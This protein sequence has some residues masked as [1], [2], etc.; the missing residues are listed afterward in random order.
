MDDSH[1][2]NHTYLLWK[3]FLLPVEH[4]TIDSFAVKLGTGSTLVAV[5]TLMFNLI[6]TQL[7]ALTVFAGVLYSEKKNHWGSRDSETDSTSTSILDF[8]DSAL[9]LLKLMIEHIWRSTL[10]RQ[11]S[12]LWA[13]TAAAFLVLQCALPIFI[14]RH[15]I[16]AHAAP[17]APEAIYIPNS[18]N[19][20]EALLYESYALRVAAYLRAAGSVNSATQQKVAVDS[21]SFSLN[22]DGETVVKLGYGYNVTGVDFGLQLAPEL[23]L[24]VQ[25]SCVTEYSWFGGSTLDPN[26][27]STDS[28]YLWNNAS[29]TQNVSVLDGGPPQA[30]FLPFDISKPKSNQSYAIVPSSVDRESFT[31]GTD[32]WYQTKIDETSRASNLVLSKR[33]PLSCWEIALWLYKDNK[34][35]ISD[36]FDFR[37]LNMSEPL[38]DAFGFALGSPMIIQMGINLG[39]RALR[40]AYSAL[41]D[42]FDANSSS[43][44]DDLKQ[45]VLASYVATTKVLEDTTT[46][47]PQK[48][49]IPNAARYDNNGTIKDGAGDFV[50][51]SKNVATLPLKMVI[52]IPLILVFLFVLVLFVASTSAV[53]S[54]YKKGL[55][56]HRGRFID[57]EA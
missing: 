24:K 36:L 11:L 51:Y 17:V 40:S 12:L 52:L 5:Y 29:R 56:H 8:R 44:H 4:G 57:T 54:A 55:A 19:L 9:H 27:W 21:P 22:E 46:Y 6:I 14:A 16:I 35:S 7:F 25:G 43:V 41:D 18:A 10:P 1:E 3:R 33:P 38:Q 39:T 47:G 42:I 15:L 26:G 31:S 53:K 23:M 13:F 45:L 32:P 48:P 20:S 2:Y 37:G 28:Y 49:G 50:I 34:G 30:F